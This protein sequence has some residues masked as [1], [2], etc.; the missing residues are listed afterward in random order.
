MNSW[1]SSQARNTKKCAILHRLTLLGVK[2]S[3]YALTQKC[4]KVAKGFRPGDGGRGSVDKLKE[5]LKRAT[6]ELF[7]LAFAQSAPAK[8]ARC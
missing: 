7:Q 5:Q 3:F 4:I 2:N 1:I 8:R 6:R